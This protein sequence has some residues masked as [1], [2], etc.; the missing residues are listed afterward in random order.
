M[1]SLFVIQ[2]LGYSGSKLS[3]LIFLTL[4]HLGFFVISFCLVSFIYVYTIISF[5]LSI[6]GFLVFK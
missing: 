1:G 3:S 6:F 5:L 2:T 4:Y